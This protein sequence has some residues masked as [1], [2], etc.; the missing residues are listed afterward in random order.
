MIITCPEC[1]TRFVLDDDLM[2]EGGRKLKCSI[3]L[4]VWHEG[5]PEPVAAPKTQDEQPAPEAGIIEPEKP[6]SKPV[7]TDESPA[8]S[9]EPVPEQ[10]EP[11]P[12]APS[13]PEATAEAPKE[14]PA[15][16]GK[17]VAMIIILVLFLAGIGVG[18]FAYLKPAEF[19]ALIGQEPAKK[20]VVAP[21]PGRLPV[22]P[23][24]ALATPAE[25]APASLPESLPDTVEDSP[26]LDAT[27]EPLPT[28]Q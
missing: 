10:A 7:T 17:R 24:P 19:K 15:G 16:G 2:P 6:A 27:R 28:Q 12:L 3:C 5:G 14:A 8:P 26:A 1:S 18:A 11:E 9:E 20:S 23:P 4:A 13:A 25:E 22:A 21:K